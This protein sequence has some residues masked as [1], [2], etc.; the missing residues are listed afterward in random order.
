MKSFRSA[1]MGIGAS[2]SLITAALAIP[3]AGAGS[4]SD[5]YR[6]KLVTVY[7]GYSVGGGYDLI[8]AH[9]SASHG[10]KHPGKP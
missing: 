7:V 9:A 5:F 8:C 2:V 1:T 3:P 4:V 6:G 10:P